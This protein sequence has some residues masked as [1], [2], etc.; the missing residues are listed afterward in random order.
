MAL[1]AVSAAVT[2]NAI[3]AAILTRSDDLAIMR[4]LGASGWMVRGP[5]LF[6]GALTGEVAGVASAGALLALFAAAQR[7]SAQMFTALLPGVD[8]RAAVACA[9]GLVLAGI[10][11]AMVASFAGLRGLSQ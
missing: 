5:F 7:A 1:A 11:L 8:W 10:G 3:R 2:A 9:A 4:L 6:E